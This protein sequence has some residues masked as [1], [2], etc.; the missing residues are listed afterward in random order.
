MNLK[1]IDRLNQTGP[2]RPKRRS[3]TGTSPQ[4]G[5]FTFV[6]LVVTVALLALVAVMILPALGRAGTN[7]PA[8]QCLNNLRQLGA[9][10]AMYSSDSR[11]QLIECHPWAMSPFGSRIAGVANPYSWAPGYA[12]SGTL[13]SYGPLPLH[14]S[15]NP[16]GLSK[17][18]F[19]KYYNNVELLKCASDKRMVNGTEGYNPIL[20][21]YSMNNWMNGGIVGAG[22][23]LFTKQEQ[24]FR[25]AATW[26]MIDEDA[27]TLDDSYF[28][29]F[30][31]G[32]GFVNLPARRHNFGY[33]MNFADG[34]AEIYKLR[35]A[36]TMSYNGPPPSG[37]GIAG[38]G[39]TA[40]YRFHTNITTYPIN[41]WEN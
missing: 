30:M 36:V 10:W 26:V 13:S 41:A 31:D 14:S 24:V 27:I 25:P 3:R 23:R 22:P 18:V 7:A 17:T 33:T 8:A 21:S 39:N 15:T 38:S 28:V 1:V 11:G 40:D 2:L 9:S 35:D 4:V 34:R 32:R 19:Y 5:A 29:T 12:G 16:I 37:A 6:D 20:R